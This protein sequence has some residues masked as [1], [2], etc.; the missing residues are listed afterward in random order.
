MRDPSVQLA[1]FAR[2]LRR[3]RR[4]RDLSQEA[5]AD[6]SG[7]SA[8]HIGEIERANKEPGI[9]TVMKLSDGLELPLSEF[10]AHVDERRETATSLA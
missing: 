6:R 7:I 9:T 4:E 10:F 5:L 1:A 3:L 2:T 8:K